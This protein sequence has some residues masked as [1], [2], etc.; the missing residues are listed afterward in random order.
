MPV[1]A[2][3]DLMVEA[4]MSTAARDSSGSGLGQD[5]ATPSTEC[6]SV[7]VRA[8][9]GTP[10]CTVVS[11][12][13]IDTVQQCR[14]AETT[15]VGCRSAERE[16]A[17]NETLASA[18]GAVCYLFPS[19]CIPERYVRLDEGEA[20]LPDGEPVFFGCP[21]TTGSYSGL[22]DCEPEPSMPG[23]CGGTQLRLGKRVGDAGARCAW[24]IPED[25]PDDQ[26]IADVVDLVNVE[27]R[28]ANGGGLQEVGAVPDQSA[29]AGVIDGWYFDDRSAP[30]AVVF[31]EQTCA[32]FESLDSASVG[33]L[34]G[35]ATVSVQTK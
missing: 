10:G 33:L 18:G 23:V 4:G 13:A 16:C 20:S 11:G 22:P 14:E 12:W 7:S 17:D 25:L 30:T 34:V 28:G 27:I 5:G 6:S 1:E 8:C 24:S 35:C 19:A 26:Q 9:E 21:T 15:A 29:C 32:K 31:C 3:G 2:D